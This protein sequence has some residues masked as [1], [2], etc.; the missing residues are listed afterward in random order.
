MLLQDAGQLFRFFDRDGAHQ[1][2]LAAFVE[3]LDLLGGVAELFFLGAVDDV[4]EFSLRSM[5][6]LVGITVTSSL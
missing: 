4:L 5:G 6:R 2:R 3:F 1:H